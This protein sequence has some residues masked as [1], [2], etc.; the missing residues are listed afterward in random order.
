MHRAIRS[1][2][3]K[4]RTHIS[5]GAAWP[6][7]S[8][9]LFEAL[10]RR[11]MMSVSVLTPL[12]DI[13]AVPRGSGAV[14]VGL[15]GRFIDPAYTNRVRFA[16]NSGDLDINLTPGVAPNTVANFLAYVN[17]GRY[18]NTI[19]HR[20]LRVTADPLGTNTANGIGIL[21][22]GG[23]RVPTATYTA[24]P[25]TQAMRPQPI[26]TNAPINLENA[27]G[28]VRGTIAMWRDPAPNTATSQFFFNVTTNTS[29]NQTSTGTGNAVFGQVL[30]ESLP[31]LDSLFAFTRTNFADDFNSAAF[32]S[33]P[34]R[35][36]P[37]DPGFVPL[38]IAPSAYLRIN[39]ATSVVAGY[40]AT[41]SNTNIATVAIVNGQ[42]VVTPVLGALGTVSITVQAISFSGNAV[43]NA[44]DTFNVTIV[45]AAP[46]ASTLQT[47]DNR[48]V[49]TSLNLYAVGVRDSDSA[50]SRVDFY[51]DTNGNGTFD[52]GIDLELGSDSSPLNGYS[53]RVDTSTFS[54][55]ANTLF[56]RIVD[57]DGPATIITQTVNMVARPTATTITPPAGAVNPR[58]TYAV[59]IAGVTPASSASVRRVSVFLDSNNDGVLNPFTDRL[60]GNAVY[61]TTTGNWVFTGKASQLEVGANLL[62][63]R[64]QDIFANL[65]TVQSTTV[66]VG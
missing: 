36:L 56:A 6:R 8:R 13:T 44:S 53:A 51:R 64:V 39:T 63:I 27:T 26:T 17:A 29:L 52:D 31:V 15:A 66:A 20:T 22:G 4:A 34:L 5:K 58:Q 50:V 16:T 47:R 48:A 23:Y 2:L 38:P 7:A 55:G 40:A 1:L 59:E 41:S 43:D 9:S 54:V 33:M 35:T 46:T 57:A 28:N 60:L 45:P 37:T 32:G 10:E 21:Q 61:N 49:G 25:P 18:D 30:T 3:A 14:T 12:P 42:L 19:F 11:E 62:F 65:G 24:T